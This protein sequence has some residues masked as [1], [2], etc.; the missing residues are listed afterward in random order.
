MILFRI[1]L[2]NLGFHI[3]NDDLYN[4]LDRRIL[5]KDLNAPFIDGALEKIINSTS[6]QY[7]PIKQSKPPTFTSHS[8]CISAFLKA[9]HFQTALQIRKAGPAAKI[10][11]SKIC[12]KISRGGSFIRIA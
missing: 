12:Q 7:E 1:H 8:Q 3:V 9:F 6:S 4:P 11:G 10:P 2:N 5:L